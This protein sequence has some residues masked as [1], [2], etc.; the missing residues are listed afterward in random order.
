VFVYL[1]V[2]REAPSLPFCR[3]ITFPPFL[4]PGR[5]VFPHDSVF[6]WSFFSWQ[7]NRFSPPLCGLS[8]RNSSRAQPHFFRLYRVKVSLCLD[9]D[10]LLQGL[11][12]GP[13]FSKR[14]PSPPFSF[15]LLFSR[16]EPIVLF[17]SS[18]SSGLPGGSNFRPPPPLR[19][20]SA[21]SSHWERKSPPLFL[22]QPH[23][24]P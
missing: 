12:F 13:V 15:F 17:S 2:N 7:E 21:L 18:F 8:S 23:S 11:F 5:K 6:F 16:N 3:A 19:R 14:L 10:T 22:S 1:S 4:L 20:I 24:L 9:L